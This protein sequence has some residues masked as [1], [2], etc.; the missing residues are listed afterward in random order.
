MSRTPSYLMLTLCHG[1]GGGGGVLQ[2]IARVIH[3]CNNTARSVANQNSYTIRFFFFVLLFRIFRYFSLRSFS[4]RFPTPW[5]LRPSDRGGAIAQNVRVSITNYSCCVKIILQNI[6]GFSLPPLRVIIVEIIAVKRGPRNGFIPP[7]HYISPSAME[8]K[9]K[10]FYSPRAAI[11]FVTNCRL[12]ARHFCQF[13][14][15]L[16]QCALFAFGLIWYPANAVPRNR[17]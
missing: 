12:R 13:F 15:F 17:G 8:K 2:V 10:N 1:G 9:R 6:P 14:S 16:G 4:F 5:L 3:C 11:A 7:F